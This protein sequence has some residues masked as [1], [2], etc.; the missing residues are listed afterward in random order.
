M[1][2]KEL[3][4]MEV[5]SIKQGG[6]QQLS[7]DEPFSRTFW[8]TT[9]SPYSNLFSHLELLKNKININDVYDDPFIQI[10]KLCNSSQ[11][12]AS[13]YINKLLAEE[14]PIG[15]DM[16]K[17]KNRVRN[18]TRTKFKWYAEE[19]NPELAVHHVYLGSSNKIP[20]KHRV[21]FTR[22]RTTL[23]HLAI[24]TGR[25]VRVPLESRLCVCGAIQTEG[26]IVCHC[27]LT[28]YVRRSYPDINFCDLS[29]VFPDVTRLCA[30][31]TDAY[32]MIMKA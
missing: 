2:L 30:A 13:E 29:Q 31:V 21:V 12:Q 27:P 15:S 4:P 7:A 3:I 17:L 26:H 23:H 10:W 25:W 6:D 9:Y 20:E 11:M 24:E 1:K 5:S 22:L 18:S 32:N 16:A 14:D 19:V 8:Q 28:A